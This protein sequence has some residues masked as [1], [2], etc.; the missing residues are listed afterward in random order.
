MEKGRDAGA[1]ADS[2][3]AFNYRATPDAQARKHFEKAVDKFNKAI[4]LKPDMAEAYNILGYCYRKLGKLDSSLQ[5][6]SGALDLKKDFAQ[7][8]E[9]RGETFLAM[10]QLDK[11]QADLA[12][13]KRLKSPFADDL[14]KAIESYQLEK[15]KGAMHSSTSKW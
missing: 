6:Y 11:A 10:G 12:T 4:S 14:A 13:L 7:A 15:V 1:K 3:F 2:S 8:Y 5:A 9:Y